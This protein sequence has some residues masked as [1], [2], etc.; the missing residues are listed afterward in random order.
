MISR[1]YPFLRIV[2]A[3][4]LCLAFQAAPLSA[5]STPSTPPARS[6]ADEIE[7]CHSPSSFE[8]VD[9]TADLP[10]SPPAPEPINRVYVGKKLKRKELLTQEF[11]ELSRE[12]LNLKAR[13]YLKVLWKVAGPFN[14]YGH[15]ILTGDFAVLLYALDNAKQR[16]DVS[17]DLKIFINVL[18]SRVS[19]LEFAT[20]YTDITHRIFSFEDAF[21]DIKNDKVFYANVSPH[22][23][24]SGF[25]AY[26]IPV[27]FCDSFVRSIYERNLPSIKA[28]KEANSFL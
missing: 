7:G 19:K 17:A 12:E 21:E 6:L 23:V 1:Q 14:E 28:I 9:Y 24:V 2:S 20:F 26:D 3:L 13:E 11:T 8:R 15:S 10:C 4:L 5:S 27:I 16:S 18:L 25:L 22:G